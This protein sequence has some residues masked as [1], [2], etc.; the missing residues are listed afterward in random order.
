MQLQSQDRSGES[1]VF[2]EEGDRGYVVTVH[3]G[4]FPAHY[5]KLF[6]NY[7]EALREFNRLA[8]FDT[9]MIK[10]VTGRVKDQINPAATFEQV[11]LFLLDAPRGIA[12]VEAAFEWISKKA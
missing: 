2:L 9:Y 3:K 11:M 7:K 5:S 1:I 10:E 4:R 8:K 12:T 6:E